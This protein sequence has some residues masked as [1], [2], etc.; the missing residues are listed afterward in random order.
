MNNWL[1]SKNRKRHQRAMNQLVRRFNKSLE[2]DE[3]WRG[4]FKISQMRDSQWWHY[5][6]GSGAELYVCLVFIDQCTGKYWFQYESVNHWRMW[7]GA[8]IWEKMNWL[9]TTHWDV[10]KEE[11]ARN[12]D[13]TAWAEYNATV[14]ATTPIPTNWPQGGTYVG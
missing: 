3:L 5:E 12:R 14:R 6:D 4:R 10:W 1:T 2:Q 9:I 7:G 13:M 8:H 11:L